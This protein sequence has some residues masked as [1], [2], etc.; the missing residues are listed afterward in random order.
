MGFG[1]DDSEFAFL[2]AVHMLGYGRCRAT[3]KIE[4]RCVSGIRQPLG[5]KD[6]VMK[7]TLSLTLS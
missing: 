2:C 1:E 4:G 6:A 7:C 3:A 5:L